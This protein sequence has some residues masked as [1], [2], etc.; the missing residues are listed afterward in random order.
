MTDLILLFGGI[1]DERL[2]SVASAQNL[3]THL[4]NAELWFIDATGAV[5]RV[6]PDELSEH[7]RPF[8]IPFQPAHEAFA[9][10]TEEALSEVKGRVIFIGLHGTEG[11]DGSLQTLLEK[12]NIRYTGSR[13]RSSQMCFDKTLAKT[14]ISD[15]GLIVPMGFELS[16]TDDS[17]K[18]KILTAFRD[19]ERLVAKPASSGSSFGLRFLNSVADC[20]AFAIELKTCA[21]DVYLIE[22]CLI[23]R[24][25]TVGIIERDNG[26]RLALPPS[27]V[28]MQTG[29]TFDYQ[30][31]YLGR[32]STEITPA[33]LT[34]KD[35][36]LCQSLALQAHIVLGCRGYSRTDM[37]LTKKGPVFL[38]TNTLPGMTKA[39]F[40]PQQLA[41]AQIPLQT[42]ISEQVLAAL[43]AN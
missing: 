19:Y 14:H 12:Q 11:E 38:E 15:S 26:K 32:G 21:Y 23:G 29:Q 17:A 22:Q 28:V 20:E 1:S 6:A 31:K 35:R 43:K 34:I 18:Q 40:I 33:E 3:A 13:S 10:N 25:L 30:G 41:A 42:F 4:R 8:E 27:E 37:M 16:K 39:S 9:K 5:T 36:D 7:Q 24:E 2:V